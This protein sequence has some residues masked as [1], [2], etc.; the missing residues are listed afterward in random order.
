MPWKLVEC[1]VA[2][3]AGIILSLSSSQSAA[4]QW[5]CSEIQPV[6]LDHSLTPREPRL[7]M[8]QQF[9]RCLEKNPACCLVFVIKHNTPLSSNRVHQQD[10]AKVLHWGYD[11]NNVGLNSLRWL[12]R[13][14]WLI[15]LIL[16]SDFFFFFSL[17]N[18]QCFRKES[19]SL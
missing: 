17:R 11:D 10:M 5:V 7:N 4:A 6:P 2:W 12:V 16:L 8:L 19:C 1:D 15:G 18:V 9:V 13:R 14:C 3:E